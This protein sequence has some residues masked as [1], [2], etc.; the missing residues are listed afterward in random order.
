MTMLLVTLRVVLLVG[1]P[2]EFNKSIEEIVNKNET[3][4]L[5]NF[6]NSFY[7]LH[8]TRLRVIGLS[9]NNERVLVIGITSI[10]YI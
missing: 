1:T 3:S 6:I 7:H 8:P 5:V 2:Q 10:F 9:E 4:L